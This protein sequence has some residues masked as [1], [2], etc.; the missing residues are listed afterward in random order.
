MCGV[1]QE[2]AALTG[3]QPTWRPRRQPS[4][5]R[6]SQADP[7]PAFRICQLAYAKIA[8]PS[9]VHAAAAPPERSHL[10]RRRNPRAIRRLL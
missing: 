4:P 2:A 6:G 7:P 3:I 1:I 10:H 9:A 5:R 8:L